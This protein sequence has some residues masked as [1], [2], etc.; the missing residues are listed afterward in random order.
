MFDLF[1][2]MWREPGAA[3][4]PFAVFNIR[5]DEEPDLLSK[6]LNRLYRAGIGGV[7]IRYGGVLDGTYFSLL[8]RLLEKAGNRGMSVIIEADT[9]PAASG[10]P[11]MGWLCGQ[12]DPEASPVFRIFRKME[13]GKTSGVSACAGEGLEA[14]EIGYVN[15]P[16][17]PDRF[18]GGYAGAVISGILE[19]YS[20][21]CGKHFGN[22]VIGFMFRRIGSDCSFP[23]DDGLVPW[24][25]NICEE[26][27]SEGGDLEMLLSLVEEP[28]VKKVRREAEHLMRKI[29]C[30]CYAEHTLDPV[31]EWCDSRKVL[32]FAD[33]A[34]PYNTDITGHLSAPGAVLSDL[35]GAKLTADCARHRGLPRC[36]GFTDSSQNLWDIQKD[37]YT[38]VRAG[39]NLLVLD[40]LSDPSADL[41]EGERE[42]DIR[43]LSSFMKRMSWLATSGTDMPEAA[44]LCSSGNVPLRQ[45]DELMKA[46]Y[47]FNYLTAE[48]FMEKAHVHGD[49]IHIDRYEYSTVLV[50]NGMRIDS[51][52]LSKL[53]GFISEGGTCH[54]N[55]AFAGTVLAGAG[56]CGFRPSGGTSPYTVRYRKSG[57]EFVI[58]INTGD[59]PV[60]GSYV[61]ENNGRGKW[62]DPVTGDIRDAVCSMADS[63]F[64]YTVNIPSGGC[65]V[66][67]FDPGALP[68]TGEEAR[69]PGLVSSEAV[70]PAKNNFT[71]DH[72]FS[73][74]VFSAEKIRGFTRVLVNGRETGVLALR[75]YTADIS[76]M[77]A[78]G[79]NVVEADRWPD[80][81]AVRLYI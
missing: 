53:G 39:C 3:C 72:G 77:T 55:S 5:G 34:D 65:A 41:F 62:L 73:K 21:N 14:Y 68:V 7:V 8:D 51:R 64:T 69:G 17:T 13:K 74:A 31:R 40:N 71:A 12:G 63:G 59:V 4:S 9:G 28:L 44:V 2:D 27:L 80:G 60:P 56:S 36:C 6:R 19:K 10:C 33:P 46:G 76:E 61:T 24:N 20:E 23:R 66:L 78:D 57:C 50:D 16:G 15:T 32:L 38:A 54:R 67:G 30:R 79:M 42:E 49:E 52:I 1:C 37:V 26:F 45:A 22:T 29:L 25:G 81:V 58:F 11:G 48:D 75:P 70:S 35:H 47:A 43:I 18:D